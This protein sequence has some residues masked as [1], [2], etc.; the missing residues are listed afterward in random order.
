MRTMCVVSEHE[1]TA[2]PFAELLAAWR[3]CRKGKTKSRSALR[4]EMDPLVHL[5]RL[6]ESL[7]AGSYAPSRARCFVVK[8]PKHREILAAEF[9]DRIVH[10]WVAPRLES[11]F[12]PCMIGDSYACRQGK[13]THAAMSRLQTMM[14]SATRNGNRKAWYLQADVASFFISIDHEILL[15]I[16]QKRLGRKGDAQGIKLFKLCKLLVVHPWAQGALLQSPAWKLAQVPPHKSLLK[17]P[18]GKG[19]PIGNL[20]SQWFANIYLNELDQFVK[21]RLGVQHY[22]RYMDDLILVHESRDQLELW[23]TAIQ[24]FLSEKLALQLKEPSTLKPVSQGADFVGYIV[25]PKYRLIRHRVT[26]HLRDRLHLWQKEHCITLPGVENAVRLQG[27]EEAWQSLE[28]SLASY[29]GHLNHGSSFRL[30]QALGK[31]FPWLKGL[32]ILSPLGDLVRRYRPPWRLGTLAALVGWFARCYP[33]FLRLVKV[34]GHWEIYGKQARW[35]AGNLGLQLNQGR[36]N[37][38][39]SL[40][41]FES[42]WIYAQNWL[43]QQRN[44]YIILG[45]SLGDWPQPQRFALQEITLFLEHL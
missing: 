39:I 30:K 37:L 41:L 1:T 11:A 28:Q 17:A 36:R 12:E 38:G 26:V 24:F 10:H 35:L 18:P 29:W 8:D 2:I 27:G 45:K 32:F 6:G 31:Q 22:L 4:F 14:R 33:Q 9:A 34:G 44:S 40:H 43:E 3:Q 19:L 16:L 13:G 5:I 20:T 23:L 42:E 7:E 15:Q 25:R 21:R